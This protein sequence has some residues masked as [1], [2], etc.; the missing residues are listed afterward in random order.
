VGQL[1]SEDGPWPNDTVSYSYA[2]RLRTSL[3]VQAPNATAW[4]QNA[5]YTYDNAG[6]VASV[7]AL[8]ANG[9][10][11]RAQE[12]ANYTYDVKG[13]VN[14]IVIYFTFTLP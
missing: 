14:E 3:S 12:M 5:N 4:A 2:N 6:E 10:T 7:M 13:S 8:S 1:L 9:V 11:N